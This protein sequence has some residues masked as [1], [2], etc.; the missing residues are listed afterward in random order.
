M[1]TH[2]HTYTHTHTHTH[3]H[4]HTHMHT[5]TC[6]R[7]QTHSRMQRRKV[8]EAEMA[9]LKEKVAVVLDKSVNDSRLIAALRAE[10]AAAELRGSSKR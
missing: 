7:T 1:R 5:H 3:T 4:A 10:V 9:S 8:V 6:T 2:T